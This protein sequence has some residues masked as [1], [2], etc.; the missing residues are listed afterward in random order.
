MEKA[1]LVDFWQFF[2]NKKSKNRHLGLLRH[3]E[4][5]SKTVFYK[6]LVL[7]ST[8]NHGTSF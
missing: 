2:E 3:F 6:K 4:R 5:F 8:T 1:P 7:I